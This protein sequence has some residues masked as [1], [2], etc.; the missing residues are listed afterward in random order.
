MGSI[1]LGYYYQSLPSCKGE[2][3][4]P[5]EGAGRLGECQNAL[6]SRGHQESNYCP[7]LYEKCQLLPPPVASS[8]P[9]RRGSLLVYNHYTKNF[10][11]AL[12]YVSYSIT[13]SEARI[14]WYEETVTTM[15][16]LPPWL[17]GQLLLNVH[18]L[19]GSVCVCLD[20][21]CHSQEGLK[22]DWCVWLLCRLQR[23]LLVVLGLHTNS[24]D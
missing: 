17:F 11:F 7:R 23:H 10:F 24:W 9:H 2:Q 6:L 16:V 1:W 12:L 18:T 3:G 21:P 14:R 4:S 5:E 22:P 13:T 19:T 8:V 15:A 20:I